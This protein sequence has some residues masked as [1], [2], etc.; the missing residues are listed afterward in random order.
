MIPGGQYVEYLV[1]EEQIVMVIIVVVSNKNK[2]TYGL[3]VEA[4]YAVTA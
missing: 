3:Y 4:F 2:Y 1:M